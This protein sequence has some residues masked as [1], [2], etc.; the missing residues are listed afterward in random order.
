MYNSDKKGKKDLKDFSTKVPADAMQWKAI[1]SE[2]GVF[3]VF[4]FAL[5]KYGNVSS[6]RNR[7]E[8][9]KERYLSAMMR[10]YFKIKSGEEGSELRGTS[11]SRRVP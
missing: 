4:K 11:K 1:G 5:K 2:Q 10:H 7:S 9:S 8:D 3:G 6:W